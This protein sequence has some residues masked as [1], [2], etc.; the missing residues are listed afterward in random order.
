M[1]RFTTL[2]VFARVVANG[3][4]A[5]AARQLN[6]SPAAVSTHIQALETRLGT[7][8]LNRTTRSLA[9]TEVRPVVY[10]LSFRDEWCLTGP[11]GKESWIPVT[12][13]LRANT[14]VALRTAALRGQ[15]LVLLPTFLVGDD[16][17]S[18][19]LVPVLHGY[20]PADAAIRAMY[21]HSRHLSAKVRTF[22]DFL[23]DRFG[24]D[25]DWD[26]WRFRTLEHATANHEH[27]STS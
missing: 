7:R 16:L 12:G 8:L 6:M 11:D 25:P 3:S 22:I 15:G 19:R 24:N 9:P 27:S 14:T 10:E 17:K 23:I 1:D 18:G 4:F 5:G 26:D 13:T 21:P 2:T 20:A